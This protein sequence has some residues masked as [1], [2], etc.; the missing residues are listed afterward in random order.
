MTT[1]EV[2]ALNVDYVQ[3]VGGAGEP[4][5]GS[6][7]TLDNHSELNEWIEGLRAGDGSGYVPAIPTSK[8]RINVVQK[9]LEAE[10]RKKTS[11]RARGELCDGDA[12]RAK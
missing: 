11:P 6:P 3:I 5:F 10:E 2:L 8:L 12:H 9:C 7:R 1:S 4:E